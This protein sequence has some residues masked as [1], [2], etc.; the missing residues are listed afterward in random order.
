MIS[1]HSAWQILLAASYNSIQLETRRLIMRA[2][3]SGW[4]TWRAMGV[5]F[6]A[7]HVPGCQGRGSHMRVDYVAGNIC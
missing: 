6:I 3:G 5:A 2:E 7:R 1:C 4:M